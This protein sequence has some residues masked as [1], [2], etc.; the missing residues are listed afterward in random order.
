M[1]NRPLHPGGNGL[2][3]LHRLLERHGRPNSELAKAISLLGPDH[4]LVRVLDLATVL[5]RQLVVGSLAVA[6]GSAAL[7]TDAG[8]ATALTL[9]ATAVELTLLASAAALAS[10]RRRVLRELFLSGWSDLP[11]HAVVRERHRLTSAHTQTSLA[12]SLDR[13]VHT[14]ATWPRIQRNCRPVFDLRVVRSAAPLL[15]EIATQLRTRQA[16][17]ETAAR[18]EQLLTAGT[19]PLYGHDPSELRAELQRITSQGRPHSHRSG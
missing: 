4:R 19:S 2:E 8:W 6:V 1:N 10:H 3:R 17:P 9:V 12:R 18:V 16:P 5:R 13:I 14:A 11:L 7:A 15:T